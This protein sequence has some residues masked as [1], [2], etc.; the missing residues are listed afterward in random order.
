MALS[1]LVVQQ[2]YQGDGSNTDFLI[3]FQVIDDDSTET[4]VYLVS[5]DGTETLQTEG[6]FQDYTLTGAN[7]PLEP[8]NTTVVFNTAPAEGEKV[9]IKRVISLKQDLNLTVNG[10]PNPEGI[11]RALDRITAICQQLAEELGRSIRVPIVLSTSGDDLLLDAS[12][13]GTSRKFIGVDSEGALQLYDPE[14]I[15]D[16]TMPAGGA[17]G[18][19]LVF[20]NGAATWVD[21]NVDVFSARFNEQFQAAGLKDFLMKIIDASYAAPSVSLAATG[22]STIREKG[23]EVTST[24]LTATITKK[25]EDIT[26]VRFYLGGDLI[27]TIEEPSASGG[28][29]QYAWTGSFTDNSTFSVQVDDS[30]TNAA[31]ASRSFTFVYPY[32]VGAGAAELSAA[33]V[34]GL[35]KRIITSTATRQETITA[36][37]GQVLYFAYPASYGDLTSI[38]DANNFETISDWTKRTENI[39][40]LDGNAVSYN[41]YE[42]NNPVVA[43]DY[44][45]TFKR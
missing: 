35:T 2:I 40:G 1:N 10:D 33:N 17:N 11:E 27:E 15:H 3:P 21:L 4:F 25:S 29:E 45:Y 44:T 26:Q 7:P 16:G 19:A 20:E 39:T 18:Y 38:L 6:E 30:N 14:E 13:I 23:D 12:S 34:A 37:A 9:I 42:F 28:A 8:I 36:T 41:I 5:E 22:S 31:N 24:T 43:G 32:Y